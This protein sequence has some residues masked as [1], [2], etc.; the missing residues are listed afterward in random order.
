MVRDFVSITKYKMQD[1]RCNMFFLNI[2]RISNQLSICIT[3][4]MQEENFT[5]NMKLACLL[6]RV[7]K[8]LTSVWAAIAQ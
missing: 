6:A 7:E 2:P 4:K 8:H 1:T 3:L 5:R